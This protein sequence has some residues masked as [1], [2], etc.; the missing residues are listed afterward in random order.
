MSALEREW[1][2]VPWAADYEVSNDGLVASWKPCRRFAPPPK[3]RRILQPSFDKNGYAKVVLKVGDSK[4]YWRVCRLVGFVWLGDPPDGHVIRH[5]DGINTNDA[6][7]NLAWGT[8]KENSLDS[9]LHGT[10]V[11]GKR[12]NTSKLTEQIVDEVLK[13]D[14]GHSSLARRYGV[15]PGAIWHIRAGRTWKWL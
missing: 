14:E 3:E 11:H 12:V 15:T 7:S 13:S 2:S 6:V 8:P 9:R 10:W 4:Q 5:M 1:K